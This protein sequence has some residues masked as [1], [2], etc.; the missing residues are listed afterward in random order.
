MKED[1]NF[2][3]N[4]MNKYKGQPLSDVP[5]N[6]NAWKTAGRKESKTPSKKKYNT[7]IPS[8]T[9]CISKKD[10]NTI[11]YVD[12]LRNFAGNYHH[13]E[14]NHTNWEIQKQIFIC[15]TEST[16]F[17][18]EEDFKD[19]C[20]EN[21]CRI[22]NF[23][24][25]RPKNEGK[26]GEPAYFQAWARIYIHYHACHKETEHRDNLIQFFVNELKMFQKV[27]KEKP[28]S[29]KIEEITTGSGFKVSIDKI[30]YYHI[31]ISRLL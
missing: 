10:M 8:H 24:C 12:M 19:L 2:Y 3:K 22:K 16:D 15:K 25:I 20:A 26:N 17:I 7:E 31:I 30:P 14:L 11:W 18:K 4:R 9:R 21:F 13:L 5:H 1:S 6:K 23:N 28:N 29:W 27:P